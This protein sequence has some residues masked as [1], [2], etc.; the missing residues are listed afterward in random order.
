MEVNHIIN[1][2][3]AVEDN[4]EP[5]KKFLTTQGCQVISVEKAKNR[6]VDALVL[7]GMDQNILGMEDVMIDVPIISA[8]GKSAEEI[9]NE[10]MR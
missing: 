2:V 5:V 8:Q 4:L 3:V 7:S 9:W 10:I 1:K 6:Q